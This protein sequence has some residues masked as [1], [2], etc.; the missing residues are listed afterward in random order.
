MDPN[1]TLLELRAAIKRVLESD[2]QDQ[3]DYEQFE[4]DASQLANAADDLDNWLS[5]G[6]FLPDAWKL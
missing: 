4:E 2:P 5:R 3:E 6:G 1:R